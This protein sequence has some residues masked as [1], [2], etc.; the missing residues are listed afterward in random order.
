MQKLEI[1]KKTKNKLLEKFAFLT[2][3][4]TENS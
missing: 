3:I 1:A 4:K 2:N